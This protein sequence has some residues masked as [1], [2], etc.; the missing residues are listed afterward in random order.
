MSWATRHARLGRVVNRHLGGVSV[1]VGAVSGEALLEQN[2]EMVIDGQ[3]LSI[4]YLLTNLPADTF[5][6][7]KRGEYA[8]IDGAVFQVR[9]APSP[10]GDGMF[11]VVPLQKPEQ[12]LV[13]VVN[14]AAVMLPAGTPVMDAGNGA[15]VA[16]TS[17]NQTVAGLMAANVAAGATGSMLVS[18]V[19]EMSTAGWSVGTLL[20]VSA[21]G[22]SP[23]V[24]GA[25]VA[26]VVATGA[27]LRL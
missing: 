27:V 9:H 22:L 4:E 18:G 6:G 14:A 12:Q 2:G 8:L 11:C 3:V 15:V 26:R 21:G 25:A 1:T 13:E 17:I 19:V 5:G 7:L 24:M 16:A 23:A 20:Y 10:V